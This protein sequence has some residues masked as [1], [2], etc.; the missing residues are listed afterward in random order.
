MSTT[1]APSGTSTDPAS[2]AGSTRPRTECRVEVEIRKG[3]KAIPKGVRINGFSIPNVVG[4]Y[5]AYR[6]VDARRV[7]IEL[8]P[9]DFVEI[10]PESEQTGS[11]S[12]TVEDPDRGPKEVSNGQDQEEPASAEDGSTEGATAEDG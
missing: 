5:A 6:P 8:M 4:V 3:A 11:T 1:E 2:S 9:T 7:T 10:D 12:G